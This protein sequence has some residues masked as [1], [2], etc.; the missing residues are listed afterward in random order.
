MTKIKLF[1]STFIGNDAVADIEQQIKNWQHNVSPMEILTATT[2][3]ALGKNE[4]GLSSQ[5]ITTVVYKDDE[6]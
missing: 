2:S 4:Y 1:G 3:T 6:S 5:T